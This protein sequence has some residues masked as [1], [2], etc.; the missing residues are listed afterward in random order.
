MAELTAPVMINGKPYGYSCAAKIKGGKRQKAKLLPLEVIEITEIV[1]NTMK[2]SFVRPNGKN[3][4]DRL[5]IDNSGNITNLGSLLM[6]DGNL[7]FKQDRKTT[8]Q[9]KDYFFKSR[10]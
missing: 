8:Q 1:G 9:T 10:H 3:G 6:I 2:V 7:F 5:Y 4:V